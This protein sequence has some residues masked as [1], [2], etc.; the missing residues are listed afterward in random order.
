MFCSRALLI[1]KVLDVNLIPI[2]RRSRRQL[3]RCIDVV[4]LQSRV[5]FAC[6]RNTEEM[7]PTA[8]LSNRLSP[9]VRPVNYNLELR[10]DLEKGEFQ[11][12]VKIDVVVKEERN[13]LYLH[14]KFLNITEVKFFKGTDEVPF[15]K[16]CEMKELEQ[17]FIH[18]DSA[19]SAGNYIICIKFNGDLTRDIVG[20]YSSRLYDC[21]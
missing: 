12:S 11:G 17:L 10:P 14:T 16:F 2:Q 19:L 4:T 18:F 7:T 13:F 21:R 8:K 9:L 1:K 3:F 15:S 5:N 6:N 20:F